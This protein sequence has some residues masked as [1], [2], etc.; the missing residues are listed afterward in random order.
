MW[1]TGDTVECLTDHACGSTVMLKAFR[2]AMYTIDMNQQPGAAR[3][4]GLRG[5][6]R[7]E[8]G[9]FHDVYWF[10]PFGFMEAPGPFNLCS[11]FKSY[12]QPVTHTTPGCIFGLNRNITPVLLAGCKP[13][14]GFLREPTRVDEYAYMARMAFNHHC[15]SCQGHYPDSEPNQ[16][17]GTLICYSCRSMKAICT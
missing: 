17:N 7:V 5:T 3:T 15:V 4:R 8:A 11:S 10:T 13:D 16:P 12:V 1:N 14:Y 9:K 6:L 2:D